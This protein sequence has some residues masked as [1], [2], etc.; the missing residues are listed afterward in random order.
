M[1]A[2]PRDTRASEMVECTA[3]A[4]GKISLLAGMEQTFGNIGW[5][6]FSL[7]FRVLR[8]RNPGGGG[9]SR[10]RA[11]GGHRFVFQAFIEILSVWF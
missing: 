2:D 3:R 9:Q 7:T 11:G 10:P 8:Q 1:S 5:D 6:V 4:G